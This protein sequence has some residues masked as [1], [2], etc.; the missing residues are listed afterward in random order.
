[1]HAAP[2]I[3]L[4]NATQAAQQAVFHTLAEQVQRY[5]GA[6]PGTEQKRLLELTHRMMAQRFSGASITQEH[7]RRFEQLQLPIF[8]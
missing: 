1:M 7:E 3:S 8:R 5:M 4:K 2:P 6:L